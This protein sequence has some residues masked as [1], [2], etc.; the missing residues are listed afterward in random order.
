MFIEM[1]D[2]TDGI[3]VITND[4]TSG[5][6]RV[7]DDVSAFYLLGY[8]SPLREPDGKYHQIDVKVNVPGVSVKAR[9]GWTS[10]VASPSPGW[11]PDVNKPA[12]SSD[13]TAALEVLARLR[14]SAELFTYGVVTAEGVRL[15]AEL[16]SSTGPTPEWDKGASVQ[17]TRTDTEGLPPIVIPMEAGARSAM[18]IDTGA[19]GEGPFRYSVRVGNQLNVVNERMEVVNRKPTILGEPVLY[20]ATPSP[21]SPLRPVANFQYWR[22]ERLVIEWPI[23]TAVESP[24]ARLLGRDGRP[25]KVPVNVT[26]R[27]KDGR[28]VL[29]ATA[30]LAPLA[31]GDFVIEL[32]A[33]SGKESI[34]RYVAIRVVR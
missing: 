33:A 18:V 22:T 10:N 32:S 2:N 23:L 30:N 25:L 3:P 15:I 28:P 8:Y 20:R 14:P 9:H 13:V 4:I 11:K 17:F 27:D 34:Q 26:Q 31:Q 7:A 29:T 12:V 21:A 1:A 6:K 16:P 19:Q 5:L 24:L